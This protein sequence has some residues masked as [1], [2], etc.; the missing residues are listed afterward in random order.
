MINKDIEEKDKNI[1]ALNEYDEQSLEI[2]HHR[3]L[4][5]YYQESI[6]IYPSLHQMK[7]PKCIEYKIAK[8]SRKLHRGKD[9]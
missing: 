4:G 8:M 7:V 2:W 9:T 5:H 1:M 3:R 6:Y